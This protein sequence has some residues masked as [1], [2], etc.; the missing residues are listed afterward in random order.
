MTLALVWL[1]FCAG[2]GAGTFQTQHYFESTVKNQQ[3]FR[4]PIRIGDKFYYL[5]EESEYNHSQGDGK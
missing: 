5:V 4:T 3:D 1:A 2:W